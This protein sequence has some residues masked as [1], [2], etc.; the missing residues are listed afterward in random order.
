MSRETLDA[1][2]QEIA[3]LLRDHCERTIGKPDAEVIAD[4]RVIFA[5][6]RLLMDEQER[7]LD[8]MQGKP[9]VPRVHF[10][11]VV[12]QAVGG[13]GVGEPVPEEQK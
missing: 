5:N 10:A 11:E 12:L 13:G 8:F 1:H 4:R 2:I 6:L 9:I 3:I 7:A